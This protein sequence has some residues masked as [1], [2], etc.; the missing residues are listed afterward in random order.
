MKPL[1]KKY[2]E[3]RYEDQLTGWDTG[4]ITTPLKTFIDSLKD[5]NINILIPGAGNAYEA[6][7]LFNN[8]FKNVTVVDLAEQPLKN[9]KERCPGMDDSRLIQTDFFV[10]DSQYDLIL[11]QTFFCALDPSYRSKYAFKMHQL[12]KP[13]GLLAGLLFDCPFDG[14]PPFGGSADEYRK[15]FEPYFNLKVFETCRNS[16][17]PRENREIFMIL[18]KK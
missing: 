1:D 13:G 12:L 10:H 17:K 5:K 8:G 9:L 2:W 6:E 4:E 11:E 14:G 3:S 7:Y 16:I 18:V 15:Y